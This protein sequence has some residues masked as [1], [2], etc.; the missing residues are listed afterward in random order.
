MGRYDIALGRIPDLRDRVIFNLMKRFNF[1]L[2]ENYMIEKDWTW[3]DQG[4]PSKEKIKQKVL[5]LL[6]E[7]FDNG[8]S[9]TINTGGFIVSNNKLNLKLSFKDDP[10]VIAETIQAIE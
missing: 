4:V 1:E 8:C 2:V 6:H 5:E 9:N 3:L 10:V 7:S